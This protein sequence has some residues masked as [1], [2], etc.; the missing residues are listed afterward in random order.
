VRGRKMKAIIKCPKCGAEVEE[1]D[2]SDFD[3]TND[4]IILNKWG[5]CTKCKVE[6]WWDEI[7]PNNPIVKIISVE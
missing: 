6:I 7:V 5:E 4:D 1:M 3:I 2:C